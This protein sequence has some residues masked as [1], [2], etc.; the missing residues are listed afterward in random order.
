[1][2]RHLINYSLK[3]F[4]FL[5]FPYFLREHKS[6]TTLFSQSSVV[7]GNIT[8]HETTS[9][10]NQMVNHTLLYDDG[11][12]KSYISTYDSVGRLG[13]IFSSYANYIAIQWE[14]G[15]KLHLPD[16]VKD[17]LEQSLENVSFPGI[18]SVR[19]CRLQRWHKQKKLE[20]FYSQVKK[21]E[22]EKTQMGDINDNKLGC[23]P[24]SYGRIMN[25]K[26]SP[27][28]NVGNKLFFLRI[29]IQDSFSRH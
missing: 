24:N 22:A 8:D 4:Q 23:L 29:V 28:H 20:V 26:I 7:L 10:T 6:I 25:I 17:L 21:C 1:M 14:L 2:D 12:R 27:G 13:N 5:K 3:I 18:S 9:S 15:Y 16:K 19:K 11:C